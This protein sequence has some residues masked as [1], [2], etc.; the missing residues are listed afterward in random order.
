MGLLDEL[1][2]SASLK[3]YHDGRRGGALDYSGNGLTLTPAGAGHRFIRTPKGTAFTGTTTTELT[4]GVQASLDLTTATMF[5]VVVPYAASLS[6]PLIVSKSDGAGLTNGY[7]TYLSTNFNFA[8]GDGAG[9]QV[10]AAASIAPYVGIP[11]M[12]THAWNGTNIWTW[13]NGNQVDLRAQTKVPTSVG[14]SYR[15]GWSVTNGIYR[16]GVLNAGMVNRVLTGAEVARLYDDF[17][18]E[19][20]SPDLIRRNFVQ[21]PRGMSDAEYAAQGICLDTDFVRRPDGKIRDNGPNNYAGTVT[22]TPTPDGDGLHLKYASDNVAFGDVAQLNSASAF[23]IETVFKSGPGNI[24]NHIAIKSLDVNNS[25]RLGGYGGFALTQFVHLGIFTGGVAKYA[26]TVPNTVLRSGASQH[27]VATFNAGTPVIYVDGESYPLTVDAAYPA[28]TPNLATASLSCGSSPLESTRNSMRVFTRA[29]TAAEVRAAYL[30]NFAQ[31][32]LL[33]ETFEDVPVS[34]G[35]SATAGMY[36]GGWRVIA[37]SALCNE[38]VDGNRYLTTVAAASSGLAIP[39]KQAFG[40][41]RFR[42]RTTNVS[43]ESTINFI[44]NVEGNYG[45]AG[46]ASYAFYCVG[47]FYLLRGGAIA[48][49]ATVP[50]GVVV[51]QNNTEY[52]VVITRRPSDCQF[53]MYIKGGTLAQWTLV[54]TVADATY[55]TSNWFNMFSTTVA[56]TCSLNMSP[57]YGVTMYQGVLDPTAGEIS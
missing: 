9:S 13:I 48:F 10:F 36:I 1:K 26:S 17:L 52:D 18:A 14:K 32:V 28:A 41:W 7:T 50:A 24:G 3:V 25:L 33:R 54:A 5:Y 51:P 43:Q 38:T 4:S 21:V 15:L 6:F 16:V 40:T 23:S 2:A 46:Q 31:K 57:S 55:L 56:N 35:V 22:G 49:L 27:V 29:L 19:G 34:L 42:F 47:Q 53:K 20:P 44:A 39:S 8:L 11:T 30:K 45:A 37:G 12:V